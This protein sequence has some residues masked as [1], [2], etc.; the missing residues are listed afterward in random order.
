[1]IKIK[2]NI[3]YIILLFIFLMDNGFYLINA[4]SIHITGAFSYSDIW[5]FMY[6]LFFGWQFI[7]YIHFKVRYKQKYFII[8]LC[9]LVVISAIQQMRL[10]GQNIWLGIRPQ[11]NYLIILLSYF[12][13]RKLF[14]KNRIDIKKLIKGLMYV[15]GVAA[16]IYISQ[17]LLY[18]N[19]QFLHADTSYRNGTLRIYLETSIVQLSGIIAI[20]YF[21]KVYKIKYLFIYLIDFIDIFWVS[22][23]RM[24]I[25]CFVIISAIGILLNNS[26]DRKK[27][28]IIILAAVAMIIF[29]NSSFANSFWN[30]V[31]SSS[32]ATTAQGNTMEIRYIGRAMYFEQLKENILTMLFGCGYP[33]I[34]YAPAAYKA[35]FNMNIY[36]N[37]NGIFGFGYIYGIVGTM[38]II[39]LFIRMFLQ[40]I[41]IYKIQDNKIYI[42]YMLML[43]LL[44][45]NVIMWYWYPAGTFLLVILMCAMEKT[46]L[47]DFEN[48]KNIEKVVYGV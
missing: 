5:L 28:F 1:M 22:Q 23:G 13:I 29:L 7:K 47:E 45:Y 48:K 26:L 15:G 37:D 36:L 27:V 12:P 11:R 14:M 25:I 21:S 42:M 38:T 20:Y 17:K 41:K 2:K 40:S 8:I 9:L 44:S 18:S 6:I 35:G 4:D 32:T 39:I 24:E 30:A 43:M 33:N 19:I 3:E 34:L 10:T 16:L 46:I 31:L